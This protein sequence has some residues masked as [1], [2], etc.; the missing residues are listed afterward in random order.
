LI[1]ALLSLVVSVT[2][3]KFV[4]SD[5]RRELQAFKSEIQPV[6]DLAKRVAPN[7]SEKDALAALVREVS[8]ER[9]ELQTLKTE[10]QPVLDLAKRNAPNAS[11][12]DA[13]AAL[14]REVSELREAQKSV[15]SFETEVAVTVSGNWAGAGA[16]RAHVMVVGE[17]AD[18]YLEIK[19][20][21]GSVKRVLLYVQGSAAISKMDA[22]TSVV[23]YRT[24]ANPGNWPI[25]EDS[26]TFHAC[27]G[28]N[29]VAWGIHKA[30]TS[31]GMLRVR[32]IEVQVFI[33]GQ[34]KLAIATGGGGPF[35][36]PI[37]GEGSPKFDF[38][39]HQEF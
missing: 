31:D 4:P 33:N 30:H 15:R 26:R 36:L 21:D 37:E 12:K 25:N 23:R 28:G 7:A 34:K 20:R 10:I 18:D 19:L 9:E 38:R 35:P 11:E 32:S 13:L 8:A 22:N 29:V 24:Q 6:L 27:E 17:S 1:G 5:E 39:H 14:V 3:N 2:W 16:P